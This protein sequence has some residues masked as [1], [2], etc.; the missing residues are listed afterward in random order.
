ME[1]Q[2]YVS[3]I[4]GIAVFVISLTYTIRH[5]K[6]VRTISYIERWNKPE[7]IEIK[8]SVNKWANSEKETEQKIHE[9]K[10]DIELQMKLRTVYSI[11]T[12]IAIAYRFNVINRRITCEIF[13]ALIPPYWNILKPF[14][15]FLNTSGKNRHGLP[16][17]YS[18]KFLNDD[19]IKKQNNYWDHSRKR[20]AKVLAFLQ[21]LGISDNNIE[22]VEVN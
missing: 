6:I 8:K 3:I 13:D 10:N 12:E 21:G 9:I 17:G 7:M 15:I 16:M 1:I 4:S 14:V 19:I 22:N 20:R 5:F 11:L 2:G 18:L